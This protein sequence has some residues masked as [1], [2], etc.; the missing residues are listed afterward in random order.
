M[1][2]F[3]SIKSKLLFAFSL[4]ILLVILLGV[5][6]I[7]VIMK[8]NKEAR[9]ILEKEL[10]LLIA[11]EQ[12]ALSMANR[13]STARGYVLFGGDFRDRFNE[14][15]EQGTHYGDIVRDI[16][17]TEEFNQLIEQTIAWR[18]MI[19]TDVF[20]EYDKGN[21]EVAIRNLDAAADMVREIMAGYEKM[22]KDSETTI[23]KIETRNYR[24]GR[25]D[26]PYRDNRH[27]FSDFI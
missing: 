7:S 20:D 6:N 10:P 8:S 22:A 25:S 5:Y 19:V 4:V 3:K 27:H 18:T 12:M 1:F 26:I 14:Y 9:N 21:K 2:N 11:N 13:I 23:N 15:T 24:W 17:A 16:R